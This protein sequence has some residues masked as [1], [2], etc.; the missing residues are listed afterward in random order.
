MSN[1]CAW[2]ITLGPEEAPAR[3]VAAQLVAYG[4]VPKGRPWPNHE[5]QWVAEAQA[6]AEANAAVIIV[7]GDVRLYNDPGIRRQLAL[8]RLSLQ[9]LRQRPV[10]GLILAG[11]VTVP[12][13]SGKTGV[14]DDWQV[15]TDE[16]WVA[17]AVARAHAPV[18]PA[19][20][21]T[22]GVHAR[23]RLG[24]WL[25]THPS[26][27]QAA[28]G[29]LLGVS[30]NHAGIS[31]HAVGPLGTLPQHSVNE[32]EL[33]GLKFE[34]AGLPYE[35][36]GLQNTLPPGNSYFVRIEGEPDML[37]IGTLPDG[38]PDHVHLIRLG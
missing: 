10:N 18:A 30:G 28:Q 29:A 26:P 16:R 13:V 25:E 7:T 6:A 32:Y 38:E 36:W 14:L 1:M 23:E 34:A 11:S 33:K 9:T 31:F 21:F 3:A 5:G 2:I 12:P 17:K 24:V 19:W 4:L 35:A 15:I 20:P 37:A 8:F 22:L 27:G